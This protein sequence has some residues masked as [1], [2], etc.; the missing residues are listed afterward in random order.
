MEKENLFELD[1][2]GKT[3]LRCNDKNVTE[4]KI[5]KGVTAIDDLA[6]AD[7][8]NLQTISLEG[9][10][11]IGKCAFEECLNLREIM[12]STSLKTIDDHAFGGCES[13]FHVV[14]PVSLTHIGEYAFA[15]C[16]DLEIVDLPET[17]KSIGSCVFLNCSS[18][19]QITMGHVD[20]KEIEIAEDAF[21]GLEDCTLLVD[22]D[23]VEAFLDDDRFSEFDSIMGFDE[24][25]EDFDDEDWE[26]EMEHT[27]GE[28]I[29]LDRTGTKVL[30]VDEDAVD[31]VIP[32]G[33]KEICWDAFEDCESLKSIT[34]PD[35]IR[36]LGYFKRCKS[37]KSIV[38]PNGVKELETDA[39]HECFSLETVE[40]PDSVQEIG[41]GAFSDCTSLK[42][43]KLPLSL[44][45]I[46]EFTFCDCSS[47]VKAS[48][49]ANVKYIGFHA[50]ENCHSLADLHLG[51]SD[52]SD[53]RIEGNAF[54][55]VDDCTLFVPEDAVEVFRA[56]DRFS[57]FKD[58]VGE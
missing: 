1:E 2:S 15:D 41:D 55:G 19:E 18:L 48:I 9:V 20:L 43:I 37:L 49:P 54:D 38:I 52:P 14:L 57:I 12:L 26:P 8:E 30:S 27:D 22:D 10:E 44:T 40:I 56:D 39:F 17:I 24:Y 35:S 4:V 3:L 6:F 32:E 58:I 36:E 53:L 34:L 47:L 33:V 23:D 5:P 29:V 42:S 28:Q 45:S 31:V 21:E 11:T 13:L 50:F 25:M 46:G 7:C 16:F 51:Q